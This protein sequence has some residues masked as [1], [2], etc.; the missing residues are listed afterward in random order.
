MTAL[1][2]LIRDASLP[3]VLAGV[4]ATLISFAGPLVI[5]FQAASGLPAPCWP[6]G[7]GR[8]RSAAACW[9]WA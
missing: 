6:R 1:G 9:G 3:A 8:S 5:V 4:V 7:C 2:Q